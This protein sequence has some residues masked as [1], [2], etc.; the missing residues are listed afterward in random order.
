VVA[1]LP[2]CLSRNDAWWRNYQHRAEDST[3]NHTEA[4]HRRL[5]T[6]RRRSSIY[7]EIYRWIKKVQKSGDVYMKQLMTGQ[8]LTIK[9]NKIRDADDRI[10]KKCA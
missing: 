4:A 5:Q 3:N 7:L 2:V 6:I 8:L 1:N 10:K 9:L